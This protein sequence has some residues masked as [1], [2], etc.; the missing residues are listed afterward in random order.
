MLQSQ[1]TA[2]SKR[3]HPCWAE[4]QKGYCCPIAQATVN[5]REIDSIMNIIARLLSLRCL[6]RI[7]EFYLPNET[8][9]SHIGSF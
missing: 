6:L 9:L 3:K 2:T 5:I 7:S 4:H 1:F 8:L